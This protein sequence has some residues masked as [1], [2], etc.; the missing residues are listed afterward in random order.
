MRLLPLLLLCLLALPALAQEYAFPIGGSGFFE[1]AN[2]VAVDT[3]SGAAFVTGQFT[4]TVDF[5]PSEAT[6]NL[7]A[8]S[9]SAAYLA[10]YDADGAFAGAF[11]LAGDFAVGEGV[12]VDAGGNAYVTGAFT[13]TVDFDPGPGA[14]ELT[15]PGGGSAFVASYTAEGALRWAFALGAGDFDGGRAIATDAEAVYVT[16]GFAGTADFDPGP[17][18]FELTTNGSTDAFV[19]SYTP[20]GAFRWAFNL[21]ATGTQGADF[22]EGAGITTDGESVWVTGAFSSTVDFDPS[23]GEALVAAGDGVNDWFL[24]KY[25]TAG[26]YAWA[27][28]VGNDLFDGGSGV[29]VDAEANAYV[30]GFFNLS[31]DFDPGAG[32]AVLVSAGN[33]DAFVASYDAD[34]GYRWAFGLGSGAFENGNAVAVVAGDLLVTGSF[35]ETVDFDPTDGTFALT[36]AAFD[37]AFVARYTPDAELVWAFD[38]GAPET[39][40]FGRGLAAAG[41][42]A[43]VLAGQFEG[44]VDFDP[45][46][47]A[48]VVAAAGGFDGFLAKYSVDVLPPLTT[49]A[50]APPE[51]HTALALSAAYPNPARGTTRL[52]LTLDRPQR[53]RVEVLDV[54]GRRVAVLHD[55]PAAGTLPLRLDA[56][57]LLTGSYVIRA[58]GAGE[59]V[60]RRVAVV[61]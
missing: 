28:G 20:D 42:S 2:A 22:D 16:G 45:T 41:D 46:E 51:A 52:S 21:G 34:G 3:A 39:G 58:V 50:G 14:F 57:L 32:Q 30:T 26:D 35:G 4:G 10:S 60:A 47:E 6:F 11:A 59:A 8:G 7:S 23:E 55:G 38:V 48:L 36:T 25:T 61:R 54:L 44:E 37:A 1:S 13:G 24:A 12:A 49:A 17:E 15:P 40:N 19:A 33:Q 27:F 29:A 31:A 18:V 9:A 56:R 43:F 5:D 53:V